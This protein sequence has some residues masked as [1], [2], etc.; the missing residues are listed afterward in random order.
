MRKGIKTR[1]FTDTSFPAGLFVSG[2][3]GFPGES[4][5]YNQWLNF[6]PRFGMA[7]DVAGDGRTS[8]RASAGTFYDYPHTFYQVGLSNAPPWS[9]R[10]DLTDVTLDN[11][12]A[13]FPGG[14]PFPMGYGKN[15]NR[16]IAWQPFSVVTA[17]DYDTPNT[18]VTQW[19]LSLQRQVGTDW[20]VSAS[21]LGTHSIHL[22]ALQQLN[23]AVFVPGV[24]DASGNC[25][26]NGRVVPFKVRR[27]ATCSTTSN[28]NQRRRFYLDNPETGIAFGTVN[29]IDSGATANYHGLVFSL[30]RRAARGVTINANHTWSHCISDPGTGDTA[31]SGRAHGGSN[32]PA[33]GGY[34]DPNNRNAD[35]SNCGSDRRH[36]FNLSAVAATPRFS[37]QALHV[38]AS[39][40]RISPIFR[41]MSGQYLHVTVRDRSLDAIANQRANQILPDVYGKKTVDD[42]LNPAAFA[43]PA[44]G[45]LGNLRP[46]SIVGPGT[47][48]FDMA[49]SRTFQFTE[50]QKIEFRAEA[51]N[52]T[53]SL[54]MENPVTNFDTGNFGQV[55]SARDPRIMQFALKYFF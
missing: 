30:Q 18:Q 36:V 31:N 6:S 40:W 50:R 22:F 13:E 27:G 37:N 17:L 7:W 34:N 54:R 15:V 4:A 24:G 1:Q 19:N 49:L 11:P 8:I 20:L 26:L 9:Q 42:Y 51:F 35:R 47:W 39:N 3:P 2:D 33:N 53:N 46:Y 55:E 45:T 12:W 41:V 44:L 5:M 21:Y 48:Q 38:V 28:T 29:R 16:N 32:D 52:I 14:D 10:T 23:P 25:T 43:R